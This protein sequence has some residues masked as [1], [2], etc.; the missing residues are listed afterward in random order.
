MRT[1]GFNKTIDE[2]TFMELQSLDCSYSF[3]KDWK[4]ER[5]PEIKEVFSI[6][7]HDKDIFIE[8]KS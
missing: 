8:V 3:G 7:P 5:I 6:I 2:M 1:T 4:N